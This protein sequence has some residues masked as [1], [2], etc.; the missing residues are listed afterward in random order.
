MGRLGDGLGWEKAQLGRQARGPRRAAREKAAQ[1]KRQRWGVF[2]RE[3]WAW[4]SR[5][6]AGSNDG[7]AG[8]VVN[9]LAPGQDEKQGT[10]ARR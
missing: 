2:A 6:L 9:A 3:S 4:R 7:D 1:A 8:A 10:E 5:G